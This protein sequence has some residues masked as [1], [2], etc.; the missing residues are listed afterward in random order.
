MI[1]CLAYKLLSRPVA[2]PVLPFALAELQRPCL[3]AFWPIRLC[4]HPPILPSTQPP[5]TTFSIRRGERGRQR[6]SKTLST[7]PKFLLGSLAIFTLLLYR[8]LC[9]IG[10]RLL[11]LVLHQHREHIQSLTRTHTLTCYKLLCF[12]ISERDSAGIQKEKVVW[13]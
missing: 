5:T 6:S 8:D 10:Q 9:L 7:L 3:T 12:S 2:C 11:Q 4:S 13:V 1:L